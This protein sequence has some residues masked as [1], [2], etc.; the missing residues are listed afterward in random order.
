MPGRTSSQSL[1]SSSIA[2]VFSI[3]LKC[4]CVYYSRKTVHMQ[5]SGLLPLSLSFIRVWT[6]QA[7]EAQPRSLVGLLK[8]F[9]S[10]Q[11]IV[12]GKTFSDGSTISL[13][14]A[15]GANALGLVVVGW[16]FMIIKNLCVPLRVPL[17]VRRSCM[18]QLP[19]LASALS[20]FDPL[21]F[22]RS[23]WGLKGEIAR[24]VTQNLLH[25]PFLTFE[26][27]LTLPS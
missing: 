21:A 10:D 23:A 9:G 14:E 11:F 2:T 26:R 27:N 22:E 7:F 3:L 6:H 8:I 19:H 18:F 4:V 24:G 20:S 13:G 25:A 17:F 15:H 1:V 16:F 12:W 5:A